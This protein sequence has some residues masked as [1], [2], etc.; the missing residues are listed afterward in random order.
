MNLKKDDTV[1]VICGD[2]RGKQGK[3][4]RVF[5]E[6]GKAIVQ[7]INMHWKHVKRGK[8][9]PHGARIQKELAVNM[10]NLML[11]C[12]SCNKP[13]RVAY[14]FSETGVKNRACKKCHKPIYQE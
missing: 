6:T 3:I 10:A 5:A 2:D 14:Q 13:T 9:Y 7:G 1:K 4:I 11:V 12:P 8:E